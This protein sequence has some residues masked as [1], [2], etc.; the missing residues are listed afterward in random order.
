MPDP[1]LV[2]DTTTL[3]FTLTSPVCDVASVPGAF[4]GVAF[5]F[6]VCAF[7]RD[8]VQKAIRIKMIFFI[9]VF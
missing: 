7:A 8:T 2:N 6:L 4:V 5:F 1:G 3:Y 9:M